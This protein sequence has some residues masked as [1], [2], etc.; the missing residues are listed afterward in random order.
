MLTVIPFSVD[1]AVLFSLD[2]AERFLE[3]PD[4][5]LGPVFDSMGKR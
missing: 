3:R 4:I 2:E 5:Q 1:L